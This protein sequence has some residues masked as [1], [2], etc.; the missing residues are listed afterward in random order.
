GTTDTL[1]KNVDST[2]SSSGWSGP[3]LSTPQQ[4]SAYD[5]INKTVPNQTNFLTVKVLQILLYQF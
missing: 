3:K 4:S 1:W 5:F 2:A